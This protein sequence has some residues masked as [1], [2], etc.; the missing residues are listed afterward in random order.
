MRFALLLFLIPTL[1]ACQDETIS[2]YAGGADH[3]WSLTQTSYGE[4]PKGVTL[5]FER[6]GTFS[7]QAPCNRYFG[8]STVP[9]PWFESG[10]IG[11]TRMACSALDQEQAYFAALTGVRLA[12]VS[13]RVLILSD[14]GGASLTFERPAP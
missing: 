3:V 4:A 12:E 7:G 1:A 10:P 13:G 2:G 9:Y 11:A 6:N 14:S 5:V 8:R